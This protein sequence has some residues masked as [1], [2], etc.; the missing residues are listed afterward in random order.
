MAADTPLTRDSFEKLNPVNAPGPLREL[1]ER[2]WT[3][4]EWARIRNGLRARSME[5]RWHV[6]AEGDTVYVHRS[7]TGHGIYEVTFVPAPAPAPAPKS[8]PK[9]APESGPESEGG[10]RI[11]A[12]TVETDPQRYRSRGGE[13]ER[14]TLELIFS[15]AVLGERADA[16]LA[17]Q[18]ELLALPPE[19]QPPAPGDGTEPGGETRPEA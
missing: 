7:W 17:R 5:E 13:Y 10:W 12:A 11:A 16:L 4:A 18:K 15:V 2:R 8:A 14:V 1:P 3:D 9:S 19:A 6:F